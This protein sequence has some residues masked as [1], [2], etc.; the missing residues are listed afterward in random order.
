MPTPLP[1]ALLDL[2]TS[3]GGIQAFEAG[4]VVIREGEIST[5]L[6]I[7]LAGELKVLTND[8]RG[9]ELIYNVLRPGEYFGEMSLDGKPRSAT[10]K[11]VVDSQCAVI[12]NDEFRAFMRAYPEF[13]EN[14]VIK[15][16]GRLRH[17]TRKL[18]SVAFDG[19]YERT[20]ALLEEAAVMDGDAR[21]IPRHLTQQEIA[22][23]VGATREM[24]NQVLRDL[25][26]G[27]FIV[28]ESKVGMRIVKKLPEHR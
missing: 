11:A 24:V 16:I 5:N 20:T 12:G 28:K 25:V 13:T 14:L 6:Y 22:N 9:R 21:R 26:R 19:V 3:R 7:L 10:V 8:G 27:G 17:A 2:L 4:H 1:Q 15:L 23:R 18:R